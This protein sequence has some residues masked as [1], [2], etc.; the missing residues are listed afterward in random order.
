MAYISNR[1]KFNNTPKRSYAQNSK[2][3]KQDFNLLRTLIPYIMCYGEMELDTC[4]QIDIIL[5]TLA[6][7]ILALRRNQ[8]KVNKFPLKSKASN[9][10]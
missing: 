2:K 1:D 4:E 6:W 9:Y 8:P 5:S 3:L 7:Y 10:Y